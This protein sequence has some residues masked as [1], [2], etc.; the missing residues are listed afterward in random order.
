MHQDIIIMPSHMT[1]HKTK[2]ELEQ[3]D[4]YRRNKGTG[5][6]RRPASLQQQYNLGC[7]FTFPSVGMMTLQCSK[8]NNGMCRSWRI[9]FLEL[10]VY[11][12]D[13]EF[14]WQTVL[15]PVTGLFLLHQHPGPHEL[16]WTL[17]TALNCWNTQLA[18]HVSQEVPKEV[19]E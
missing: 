9:E 14:Y 6:W 4:A 17:N 15:S 10:N 13:G 5:E 19:L 3:W 11:F 7:T 1:H 8:L 12:T 18:I 2:S 16:C